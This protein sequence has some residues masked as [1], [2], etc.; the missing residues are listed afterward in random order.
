MTENI[1]QDLEFPYVYDDKEDYYS[2]V[3]YT[4]DVTFGTYLKIWNDTINVTM[5]RKS[6]SN[7][8]K[9]N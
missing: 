3:D 7:M 6:A 2:N 5:Y 4:S 1:E 9:Y 8:L